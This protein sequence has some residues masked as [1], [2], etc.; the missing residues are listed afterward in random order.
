MANGQGPFPN[1]QSATDY[2]DQ[3]LQRS[4]QSVGVGA[5]QTTTP[6]TPTEPIP[7]PPPTEPT[8]PTGGIVGKIGGKALT[9]ITSLFSVESVKQLLFWQIFAQIISAGGNPFLLELAHFMNK[10]FPHEALSPSDAATA[11]NRDFMTPTEG[12][13]E[14][15][16]SGIDQARFDILTAL[17]GTAPSPGVLAEADRRGYLQ[18]GTTG[19]DATSF[20]QGIKEGNL[21]N[22]WGPIIKELSLA[23]PSPT[24]ML[25]ALLEGQIKRPEA[26][27]LYQAFGGATGPS[28]GSTDWFDIMYNTRGSAPTPLEAADMANR[29]IIPWNG[30]GPDVVSYEQS[31][32][33]GPW[34]NKWETPYRKAAERLPTAP[35]VSSFLSEGVI[36]HAQAVQF[37]KEL[38]MTQD[39]ATA[40]LARASA[41]KTTA[42]KNLAES[43]VNKLYYEQIIDRAS[44]KTF[45]ENLKYTSQEADFILEIVDLT[46]EEHALSQA[47][48]RIHTLYVGH[49]I[50]AS[51]AMNALN[52]LQIPSTQV[53]QLMQLWGLERVNNVKVLSE[54]QIVD[55]FHYGLIDQATAQARLEQLGYQPHDAWILLSNKEKAK[56]PNEPAAD[57]ITQPTPG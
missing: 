45:L 13:D 25:D 27:A 2:L 55:A 23:T 21:L 49:K 16:L 32:L 9:G 42:S 15:A 11:V 6:S 29:G 26:I 5:F 14:A 28:K 38:G 46:R 4:A 37:L 22:K 1:E 24:D 52:Q 3:Y 40:F 33:E 19:K 30:T 17:A 34:R 39:T 48:G 36:T 41:T 12:T 57:A 47:T 50:D 8:P 44:A 35:E 7:A 54:S 31:F 51:T 53:T 43:T 56:L 18:K 10:Q 20:E